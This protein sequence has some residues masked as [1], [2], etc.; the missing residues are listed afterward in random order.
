MFQPLYSLVSETEMRT[1]ETG[2]ILGLCHQ[3]GNFYVISSS[4]L[5]NW[6]VWVGSVYTMVVLPDAT[7]TDHPSLEI[8]TRNT[9]VCC[10]WWPVFMLTVDKKSQRDRTDREHETVSGGWHNWKH[11]GVE[12]PLDTWLIAILLALCTNSDT[13]MAHME[14]NG[15]NKGK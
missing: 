8:G 12:K 11:D 6:D 1:S 14:F 15:G 4:S 7:L 3:G 2:K 5:I 10:P 13:A 9:Q